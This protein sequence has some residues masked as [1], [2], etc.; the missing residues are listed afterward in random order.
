M[1]FLQN[2]NSGDTFTITSSQEEATKLAQIASKSVDDHTNKIHLEKT[3]T[4]NGVVPSISR[5]K[6]Q[7]LIKNTIIFEFLISSSSIHYE[8]QKSIHNLKIQNGMTTQ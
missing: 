6:L 5:G 7:N 3:N 8:F 2:R 4:N 1:L